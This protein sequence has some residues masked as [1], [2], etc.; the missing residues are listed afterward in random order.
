MTLLDARLEADLARPLS[1]A[2]HVVIVSLDTGRVL[3][4]PRPLSLGTDRIAAALV[5]I[6]DGGE[7]WSCSFVAAGLDDLALGAWWSNRAVEIRECTPDMGAVTEGAVRFSGVIAGEPEQQAGVWSVQAI[8]AR[9][10]VV[11]VPDLGIVTATDW[12]QASEAAMG[13]ALPEIFGTVADCPLLPVAVREWTPLTAPADPGQSQLEVADASRLAASGSVV[14]DGVT[15]AYSDR[16]DT[17]LLG[18][19]ITGRHAAGTLVAQAG[20]WTYLAAGHAV[21]AIDDLRADGARIAGGSLD[22]SAATVSFDTPP[23]VIDSATRYALDMHFDALASGTTASNGINA[24]RAAIGSL[25]QSG[26]PSGTATAD[27]PASIAFARP[28]DS[29][30]IISG[31]YTVAFSVAVGTQVGAASVRIGPDIVWSYKPGIGV[32]FNASPAALIID[33]DADQIPVTVE[34]ETGGSTDQVVVTVTSAARVVVTGNLD[35][36]N[37]ATL[38]PGKTLRVS[39]TTA[40]PDRGRIAAARLVVR[41]FATDSSLGTA[42]VSLAGQALGPLSL[43]PNTGAS[44]NK[45]V[46]VDAVTQGAAALP[47]TAISTTATKTDSNVSTSI[48][49]PIG[50][51]IGDIN[52]NRFIFL[53]PLDIN[54]ALPPGVVAGT[55]AFTLTLNKQGN[56]A[57]SAQSTYYV[58]SAGQIL[59]T[60]T[61]P[62]TLVFSVPLTDNQ[63]TLRIRHTQDIGFTWPNDWINS[64]MHATIAMV[65]ASIITR[66]TAAALSV[67]ASSSPIAA[68][69]LSNAGIGVTLGNNAISLTVPAPPRVV[70][71]VFDLPA[72][73]AWSDFGD[74]TTPLVAEIALS[75]GTASLCVVETWLQ[76]EYDELVRKPAEQITATVTGRDGNPAAV[77]QRLANASGQ[78]LDLDAYH[79]LSDW[80]DANDFVFAR[81]LSE[82]TDALTLLGFAAEQANVLLAEVGEGI[83]P[84]RWS[85]LSGDVVTLSETDLLAPARIG[86]ADRVETA[87]TLRY[88]ESYASDSG[89]ARVAQA[90]AA[91]T[92][93]CRRGEEA[94]A[95]TRRVDIDAGWIRDDVTAAQSLA[96]LAARV[97]RPRRVLTLEC[98]YS[99]TALPGDLIEYLPIDAEAGLGILAR[100]TSRSTD[101]GWPT[102]TAEEIHRS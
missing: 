19:T 80:C 89:F 40:N 87:I 70:N 47:T 2:F 21:T 77:L 24:I 31:A 27:A 42:S 39:Q 37:F 85:D 92:A 4:G 45:T 74:G 75:G 33:D 76:V 49:V 73:R 78:A 54:I 16:S 23:T 94:I 63:S 25:S 52:V 86:W 51:T 38:A 11:P 102:L 59:N 96:D 55:Y 3:L 32:L 90:T 97:A 12:P 61:P 79:R 71:T 72:Y 81:R 10:R 7:S 26:T 17:A 14:V 84:V 50:Y 56:S 57:L 82:P 65:S 35:E 88:A 34:V 93:A 36:A 48:N 60:S 98:P 20:T 99:I 5:E 64:Q 18:M 1:A 30:R 28:S 15:Y 66:P 101:G 41:W 22:L 91:N 44:I 62:A 9:R 100:I 68:Q 95:E 8:P 53:F 69:Q 46:S 58:G 6:S 67:S 43:T 83:A 29:N 13:Q